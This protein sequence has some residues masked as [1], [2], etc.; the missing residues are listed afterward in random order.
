MNE[1]EKIYV[2]DIYNKIY[3]KFDNSRNNHWNC[4]K[5]YFA[6]FVDNNDNNTFLDLGCG[7][8]KNLS[9]IK[10]HDKAHALD[11]SIELIKI[12]QNKFPKINIIVS[13]VTE[14]PIEN[15]FF[16]NIICI[17]VIHHLSTEQRRIQLI[18]EI[19]R[20][21]KIGGTCMITSWADS[22]D[23]T[24]YNKMDNKNDYLI[25]WNNEC[26]RF[27]HL[28]EQNEFD[29]I[30]RKSKYADNI[31]IVKKIFEFNNW[32]IIIKKTSYQKK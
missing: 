4:V 9:L 24:K 19:Y 5:E 12:V 20:V 27:Y 26:L 31:V 3:E 1:I 25:P 11:N 14:I 7:N 28:F 2:N 16:D 15:D 21:L 29:E 32:C 18:N 23:T 22:L 17:A 13:D 8:G 6:E 30:I 10:N